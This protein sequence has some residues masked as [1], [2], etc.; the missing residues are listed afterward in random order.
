MQLYD[1]LDEVEADIH[2][3]AGASSGL[4]CLYEQ[5]EYARQKLGGDPHAMVDDADRDFAVSDFDPDDDRFVALTALRGVAIRLLV[6]RFHCYRFADVVFPSCPDSRF[7]ISEPLK[8]ARPSRRRVTVRHRAPT[9]GVPRM[10]G[11][12]MRLPIQPL[13]DLTPRLLRCEGG[14]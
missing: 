5:I 11:W 2:S 6:R 10:N 8:N 12:K 1:T 4:I 3:V 14:Q 7:P 13:D 9:S